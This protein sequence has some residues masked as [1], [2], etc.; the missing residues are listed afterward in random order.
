MLSKEEIEESA[1]EAF[2]ED[3]EEEEEDLNLMKVINQST[4]N[5]L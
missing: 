5:L 2:K 3:Y 4:F 1:V